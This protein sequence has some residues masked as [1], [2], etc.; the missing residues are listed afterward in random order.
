MPE[1]LIITAYRK[2]ETLTLKKNR[3]KKTNGNK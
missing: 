2:M 3:S 1:T